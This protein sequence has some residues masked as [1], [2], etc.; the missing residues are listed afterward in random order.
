MFGRVF[1]KVGKGFGEVL[2]G[3]W[4]WDE[5]GG[6]R[7]EEEVGDAG[8]E[9]RGEGDVVGVGVDDAAD[10]GGCYGGAGFKAVVG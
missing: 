8:G 9:G 7:V 3:F 10:V 2:F 4:G 5:G 6:K 1:G